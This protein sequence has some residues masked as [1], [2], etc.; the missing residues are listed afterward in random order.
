ML[1]DLRTGHRGQRLVKRYITVGGNV[2]LD[3]L[4]IDR[5]GVLQHDPLLSREKRHI[6][7]AAQPLDR[8]VCLQALDDV[9]SIL[10][11]YPL[12]HDVFTRDRHQWPGGAKP[13][14]TDALHA[15]LSL[16]TGAPD[17]SFQRLL[18]LVAL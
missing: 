7:G 5:P 15:T 12:I 4:R 9:G 2:F 10:R 6:G 17:L 3:S 13:H 11:S 1:N 8:L 16:E 18:H 14:A